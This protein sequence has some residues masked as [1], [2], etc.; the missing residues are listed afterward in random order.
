MNEYNV[1]EVIDS[2]RDTLF[3]ELSNQI[4]EKHPRYR[5][6]LSTVFEH[7]SNKNEW[8]TKSWI[9][10][11]NSEVAS[12]LTAIIYTSEDDTK[13]GCFSDFETINSIESVKALFKVSNAWFSEHG[14]CSIKGPMTPYM[15]DSRGVLLNE[16]EAGPCLGLTYTPSYY[17]TLFANLNFSKSIDL[18]SYRISSKK[19][20]TL[21]SIASFVKKR[22]PD[23]C[24]R[25]FDIN[26]S[27]N[28]LQK[29]VDIYNKSWTDHWSFIPV[30]VEKLMATYDS[31]KEIFDPSMGLFV[32]KGGVDVGIFLSVPNI[33]EEKSHADSR[34]CSARGLLF[35]VLSGYQRKGF[36]A[37]LLDGALNM[38]NK[39]NYRE[40][41]IGW[42]LESNTSWIHQIEK[43]HKGAILGRRTFRI[44]EYAITQ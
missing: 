6:S 2:N 10:L 41:E 35:G 34:I 28:E 21:K 22:N 18:Y 8:I 14:V 42:V 1:V 15:G 26:D 3:R 39:K 11:K 44:Y 25:T 9:V 29:V 30:T 5:D 13:H 33:L 37:L 16:H 32:T 31:F 20:T 19:V 17:S 4:Y 24:L 27:H 40:Y 36:D 23:V 12:R 38:V 7:H 43:I